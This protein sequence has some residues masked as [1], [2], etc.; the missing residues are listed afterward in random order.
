VARGKEKAGQTGKY[1]I[2]LYEG[3]GSSDKIVG[4]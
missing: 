2:L 1:K 3:E 4:N